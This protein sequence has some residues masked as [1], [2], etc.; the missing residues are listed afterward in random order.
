[1][2]RL[3]W[4]LLLSLRYL[5]I[6]PIIIGTAYVLNFTFIVTSKWS[7]DFISPMHPIW[8]KSSIFS[9]ELEKRWIML[10]TRRRFPLINCS[11][12]SLSP[13]WILAKSCF[14]SSSV[15]SGNFDVFTPQISTLYI[16]IISLLQP[17]SNI[18]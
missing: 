18:K 9:P 13:F 8:N 1:M 3:T 15:R 4:M 2:E 10:N 5:R 11:L 16:A 17:L 6:S 12:A 14:F 7:M